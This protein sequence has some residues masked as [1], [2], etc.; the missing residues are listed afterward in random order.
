M[1]F[2]CDTPGCPVNGGAA[3]GPAAPQP[4]DAESDPH[5]I[6]RIMD[7][8]TVLRELDLDNF[9]FVLYPDQSRISLSLSG[10]DLAAIRD[11]APVVGRTIAGGDAEITRLR[12]E[13][14]IY[15]SRDEVHVSELA[16]LRAEIADYMARDAAECSTAIERPE[17]SGEDVDHARELIQKW[18][19]ADIPIY[20]G[21]GLVIQHDITAALTAARRAGAEAMRERADATFERMWSE[22]AADGDDEFTRGLLAG[23]TELMNAVRALPT[24]TDA[25]A[26]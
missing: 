22:R 5:F 9:Q 15:K 23:M 13:L 11:L 14:A 26:K 16:H 19:D 21:S 4:G 6:L 1:A 20:A 12:A 18:I 3:Y 7:D 25:S 10:N 2:I 8:E 24:D 17:A